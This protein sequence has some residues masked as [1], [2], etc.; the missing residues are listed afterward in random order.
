MKTFSG[1]NNYIYDFTMKSIDGKEV[2]LS[3]YK[4]EVL[5]VVNVASECGYTPQYKGLQARAHNSERTKQANAE[6]IPS[7]ESE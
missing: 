5:L 7:G 6:G 2:S 3:K 4:G 1:D